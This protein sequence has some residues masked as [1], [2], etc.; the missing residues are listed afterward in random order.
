[1]LSWVLSLTKRV[2]HTNKSTSFHLQWNHIND[3]VPKRVNHVDS[4]RMNSNSRNEFQFH[5]LRSPVLPGCESLILLEPES[6]VFETVC[7]SGTKTLHKIMWIIGYGAKW[8]MWPFELKHM[9]WDRLN[10]AFENEYITWSK[11]CKKIISRRCKTSGCK[12]V[13]HPSQK[14]LVANVWNTLCQRSISCRQ[15]SG[16]QD[17]CFDDFAKFFDVIA[18]ADFFQRRAICCK[19]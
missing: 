6:L 1:M 8:I 4:N 11:A 13:N 5:N 14:H 9:I 19:C 18:L 12:R 3:T 2:F 17:N 15:T 16:S 7:F 10:F